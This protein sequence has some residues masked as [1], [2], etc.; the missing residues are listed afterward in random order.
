M[1][2]RLGGH[3]EYGLNLDGHRMGREDPQSVGHLDDQVDAH[4]A[5]HGVAHGRL[6]PFHWL[7]LGYH[8]SAINHSWPSPPLLRSHQD[9]RLNLQLL[10]A[11]DH[12]HRPVVEILHHYPRPEVV[13]AQLFHEKPADIEVPLVELAD[14]ANEN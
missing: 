8:H 5:G 14:A 11:L 10:Q 3:R 13:L 6:D 9:Q 2:Q 4:I 1:R 7:I 12:R